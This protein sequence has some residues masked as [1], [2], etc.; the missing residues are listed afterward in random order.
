[1]S[2]RV[3]P[4]LIEAGIGLLVFMAVAIWRG[5]F[6]TDDITVVYKGLSDAFFVPGAFMLGIGILSFCASDGMFDIFGYGVKSLKT[7][8]T[9][10]GRDDEHL[11][12]YD[13]KQEKASRRGKPK[14]RSMI[15]GL[16]FIAGAVV[17]LLL[18]N[19]VS[20]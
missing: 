17:C 10:F 3:K 8:F 2:D 15:I 16:V 11:R 12:Y 20:G 19:R 18:Y 14:Y 5:V 7:L 13:Y 6:G 4:W 1:M 9:P